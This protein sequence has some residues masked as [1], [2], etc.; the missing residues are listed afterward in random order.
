MTV[1]LSPHITED[2]LCKHSQKQ[3]NGQTPACT[4]TPTYNLFSSFYLNV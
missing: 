3:R 2:E 4:V 1:P